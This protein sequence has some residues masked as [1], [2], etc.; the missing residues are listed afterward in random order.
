M[1]S[2]LYLFDTTKYTLDELF[3][4]C[5]IPSNLELDKYVNEM[6]KK[7]IVVSYF[8]K[9]KYIKSYS[10][11]D[12]NKP[13][14]KDCYFNISHSHGL[15]GLFICDLYEVGLDIEYIKDYKENLKKHIA[16][17][18]EYSYI[19]SNESF[20]EI[21][22]NKESLLKCVGTGF[23]DLKIKDIPTLSLNGLKKYLNKNYYSKNFRYKNYI[24][25][26]TLNIDSDYEFE[27]INM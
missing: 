27:I 18:E 9:H 10:L 20:Y 26:I 25:S 6:I 21:W 1:K 16:N 17:E 15:V 22:T 2:T 5:E 7:E 23:V 13:I 3:S 4:L 19:N 12:F 14:S 24:I 11:N 8:L